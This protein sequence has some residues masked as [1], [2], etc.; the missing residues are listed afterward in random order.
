[1]SDLHAFHGDKDIAK[2]ASAYFNDHE[3][4]EDVEFGLPPNLY[5]G[6]ATGLVGAAAGL[7]SLAIF[8]LIWDPAPYESAGWLRFIFLGAIAGFFMRMEKTLPKAVGHVDD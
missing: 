7:L 8:F 5:I 3:E 6:F 4:A 1:M 2:T